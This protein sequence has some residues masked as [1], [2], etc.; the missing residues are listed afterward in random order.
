MSE[1]DTFIN[2]VSEEVRRDKLYSLMRKYGWIAVLLVVL[3]VGGAAYNEWRK[4]NDRAAAQALGDAILAAEEQADPNQ[5]ATA[6]ASLDVSGDAAAVVAMLTAAEGK[7]GV[8]ALRALADDASI[9]GLYR[10][11]AQLKLVSRTASGLDTTE[12]RARLEPLA[13]PGAPYR[14][15]AEEQLALVDVDEGQTDAAI[16]RLKAL[17][18]DD[19]A[20]G[21]L[22]R[23]ASQLIV[24]LGGTLETS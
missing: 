12:R 24:A 2:E 9:D 4:A 5:R 15:L 21:A 23:R 20:S 6:L 1:T 19:E 11:L 14:V 22:R 3:L 17:L 7:V 16:A 10:D 8:D 18:V 13:V